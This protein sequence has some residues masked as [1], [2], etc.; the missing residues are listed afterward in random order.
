MNLITNGSLVHQR[1]VQDGLRRMREI[2]GEVWF[3]LDSATRE[4]R[5]RVNDTRTGLHHVSRNLEIASLACPTWIQTCVLAIDGEPPSAEEQKAY[6][7][8]IGSRLGAGLPIRGVLL[9]GL[10]RK[11]FQPEAPRLASLPIAWMEDYA[12]RIRALGL[13]VKVTA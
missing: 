6:L 10:A 11:S 2:S 3:K 13:E 9:Y 5:Q 7:E 12:D 1:R 4:G 8:F